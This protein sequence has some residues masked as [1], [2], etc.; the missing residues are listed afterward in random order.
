MLH[1]RFVFLIGLG[2]AS[3]T[4]LAAETFPMPKAGEWRVKELD[5]GAKAKDSGTLECIATQDKK[6]W[7]EDFKKAA[8]ANGMECE[9][10][11]K[12]ETAKRLAYDIQCKGRRS[13]SGVTAVEVYSQ[14]AEGS[15]VFN[16]LSET[17]YTIEQ[18]IKLL[19][20]KPDGTDPKSSSPNQKK[21]MDAAMRHAAESPTTR[22]KNEYTF[23]GPKCTPPKPKQG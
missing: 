18:E 8:S 7:V 22:M 19:K 17:S 1:T 4:A 12:S 13:P 14:D 15:L 6:T 2:L 20:M 21:M 9:L 11:V 16:R 23:V 5:S 3:S 10:T